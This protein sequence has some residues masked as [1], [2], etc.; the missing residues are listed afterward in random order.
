MGGAHRPM[1]KSFARCRQ[2]VSRPRPAAVVAVDALAVD[3]VR[4]PEPR[5]VQEAGT[6]E[7]MTAHAGKLVGLVVFRAAA[8]DHFIDSHRRDVPSS[9]LKV[10]RLGPHVNR[11]PIAR[12]NV[13]QGHRQVLRLHLRLEVLARLRIAIVDHRLGDFLAGLRIEPNQPQAAVEKDPMIAAVAAV[14][15][16]GLAGERAV[17]ESKGPGTFKAALHDA[18]FT[19]AP[20]DLKAGAKVS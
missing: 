19:L 17:Q 10:E 9:A 4:S 15:F 18:L 11:L 3:P 12:K 14:T 2:E 6:G 8:E 7:E 13:G 1:D 5:I 16:F 20:E